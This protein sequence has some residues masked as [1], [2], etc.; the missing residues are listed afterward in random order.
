MVHTGLSRSAIYDRMDKKSTRYAEDFPKSFPLSGGAVGWFKNEVDAWLEACS[1]YAKSG[2][3]SK[4]T[5]PSLRSANLTTQAASTLGEWTAP[6]TPPQKSSRQP[7][8]RAES[9]TSQATSRRASRPLNLAEA[10][11][12]GGNINARLLHYLQ[13]K[14]WTPAMGALLISGIEPPRDC[15]AIPD[16]GIGLDEKPLHASD[17]RFH[18]A[19]L[20]LRDWHDW[21][22][23]SGDQSLEIEP[24]GFLTWCIK[25]DISTEW[26]RLFLELIGCAD[27]NTV[28]LTAS[29]F[30][31]LTGR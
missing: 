4:K 8:S 9:S 24:P 17:S 31:L 10:I 15:N 11:V 14:T 6:P 19:R 18:Q 3:S 7:T 30:A 20:I 22:E 12:E 28:D 23:D 27:G 5:K 25:E 1:T 16:E 29:R 21:Q 26:M 13:F 2:T